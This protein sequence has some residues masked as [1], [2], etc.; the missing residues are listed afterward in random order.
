MRGK[1]VRVYGGRL[2][3]DMP[4]KPLSV[5]RASSLGLLNGKHV[6]MTTPMGEEFMLAYGR[7]RAAWVTVLVA[8]G[9]A[10]AKAHATEG[11]AESMA[12]D[13]AVELLSKTCAQTAADIGLERV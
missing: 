7:A 11:D 9:A 4:W 12:N 6:H 3:N 8:S 2:L 13:A 5:E 1:Q 10:Y